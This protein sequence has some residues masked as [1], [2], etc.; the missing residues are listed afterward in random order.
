MNVLAIGN[1]FS[2][3][4]FKYLH[5]VARCSGDS[6][7]TVN[8]Y[9]GGC[10][11]SKHYKNMLADAKDY[12]MEFNGSLTGFKVSLKE[13]LLNREWDYISL[14]QSSNFSPYFESYQPYLDELAA[15]VRKHAPKAKIVIHQTWAYEQGSAR[16]CDELGYSDHKDMF[17]DIKVAYAKAAEAISADLTIPSGEV[18]QNL[19]KYGIE[20]VH[21]DT[22]HAGLGI[23]R[24]ALALTWYAM[25]SGKDITDND[26]SDFD[27]EITKSDIEI[28]KKAVT[29][30]VKEYK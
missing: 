29:E 5:N 4:A 1:S 22:F 24:Y 8:L 17:A 3:D 10:S 25:L 12:I 14:Q 19:L 23:G 9:I 15:Y 28:I 6:L 11:L 7:T 27:E 18:F 26:F 16:L 30:T 2:Q 20:K 13:A 21:R